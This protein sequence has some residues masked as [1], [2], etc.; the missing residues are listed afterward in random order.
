MS[1]TTATTPALSYPHASAEV[2]NHYDKLVATMARRCVDG[3]PLW[4]AYLSDA[5]RPYDHAGGVE[6]DG[7]EGWCDTCLVFFWDDK[8]MLSDG[9]TYDVKLTLTTYTDEEFKFDTNVEVE[10]KHPDI[11]EYR[12]A[13]FRHIG[14]ESEL[15]VMN[16]ACSI[17][18]DLSEVP[19]EETKT[20]ADYFEMWG[21]IERVAVLW[22]C[23][24]L[25]DEFMSLFH[26][27]YVG[28]MASKCPDWTLPCRLI[29]DGLSEAYINIIGAPYDTYISD[30]KIKDINP[31]GC[32][33]RFYENTTPSYRKGE[34]WN[35]LDTLIK[36][37]GTTTT[38][39][40]SE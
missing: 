26:P 16:E 32:L 18:T 20:K 25:K 28:H 19:L 24:P 13:H 4:F 11:G 14:R 31:T 40:V 22:E 29:K 34:F 9:N 6:A 15:V 1:A 37:T 27:V 7:S 30:I 12:T 38:I 21:S 35:I 10:F 8:V 17:I 5:T 39:E 33:R 2:R 36:P 3:E 23:K